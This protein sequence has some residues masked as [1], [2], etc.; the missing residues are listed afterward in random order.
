M[1]YLQTLRLK[2]AIALAPGVRNAISYGRLRPYLTGSTFAALDPNSINYLKAYEENPLIFSVQDW[3]ASKAAA[4][5]PILFKE[6]NAQ[7]FAEYNMLRQKNDYKALVEVRKIKSE[8]VE[9]VTVHPILKLINNPNQ[10]QTRNEL[11]ADL[12]TMYDLL[13]TTFLWGNRLTVGAN[14]GQFTELF[15]LTEHNMMVEGMSNYTVATQYRPMDL[16]EPILGSD[17]AMM[18]R[19]SPISTLNNNWIMGLSR[20][21]PLLNSVIAK[22]KAATEAEGEIYQNRGVRDLI[23]PDTELS[24]ETTVEAMSNAR[25]Q[26]N[27]QIE[28][29]S[30]F[31]AFSGRLGSIK[32]GSSPVDLGFKDAYRAMFEDVCS[33]YHVDGSVIAS[34]TGSTFNNINSARKTSLIDGVLPD[35]MQLYSILNQFVCAAWNTDKD[36]FFLEPDLDYYPELQDEQLVK[37]QALAL[38]PLRIDEYRQAMGWDMVGGEEGQVLIMPSGRQAVSDFLGGEEIVQ[39]EGTYV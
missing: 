37:A 5:P 33:V 23:F 13:G 34:S 20:L 9:E 28:T 25:K 39:N 22:Y 36:T 18:H 24:D 1:N 12:I 29:K 19:R 30:R 14:Q 21:K 8:A 17:V 26:F 16:R 2:A 10:K 3:K 31:L 4:A 6:R 35:Q 7:K 27:E 11:F 32:I 38:T 15:K